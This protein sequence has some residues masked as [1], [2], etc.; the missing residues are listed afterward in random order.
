MTS[1]AILLQRIKQQRNANTATQQFAD[2]AI[3]QIFRNTLLDATG[4]FTNQ[5]HQLALAA[6]R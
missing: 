4:M 5:P 6:H 3:Q 2:M 1:G